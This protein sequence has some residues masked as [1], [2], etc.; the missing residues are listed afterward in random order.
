MQR[1]EMR[2]FL[3][4]LALLVL[5]AGCASGGN[6]TLPVPAVAAPVP[7]G[8]ARVTVTR[9]N[10][11]L[12]L[13]LAAEVAVNDQRA[14]ALYRGDTTTA[15]VPAGT[16]TVAVT[17]FGAP[18]RFV[19]RF[20]TV[21]GGRY[22]LQAAPRGASVMPGMTMGLFGSML[23]AAANPEQGGQFAL[24]IVSAVP[25]IGS[26]P[27]TPPALSVTATAGDREERLAEL[28]RLRERG[29]ITEEVYRE[30]QRRV[31]A[32]LTTSAPR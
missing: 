3:P 18:G 26:P 30:E 29:L 8:F 2:L 32:P 13:A 17:A 4:A 27:P 24:A 6:R 31:L 19:L 12:F 25:P 9:T 23:D 28:R 5:L 15:D 10:D 14:G 16:T 11:L 20:P 7:E 22:E 1:S 21:S